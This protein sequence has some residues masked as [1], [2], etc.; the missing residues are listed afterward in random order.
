V[1]VITV[2]QPGTTRATIELREQGGRSLVNRGASERLV[3]DGVSGELKQAPPLATPSAA[4]AVYNVFTSAHLG[5]FAGPTLRWL[6]FLSGVVGTVMVGTGMVL[7]VVKRL[8]DRKKLGRTPW[9]H[10]FVEVMNVGGIAGL[11]LATAA[12]FWLNRLIPVEQAARADAEIHG[13][14]IVWGLAFVHALLRPH[15][16]AW[17]EQLA[18]STVLFALLPVLNPLTGG[19][20][21]PTAFSAGQWSVAGFD[22]A[23][24]VLAALHGWAAWKLRGTVA[25]PARRAKAH[26]ASAVPAPADTDTET[27]AAGGRA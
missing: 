26:G 4:S 24:L 8:P 10:R 1:G 9:G 21:L 7:W 14:F 19:H 5:R 17:R 16:A 25:Q 3:F 6:L 27:L 15:R 13:F 2:Q 11:S 23:M 12:Y 18:L 20:G 22:L